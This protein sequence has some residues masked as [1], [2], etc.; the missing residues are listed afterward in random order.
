MDHLFT[1]LVAL[2]FLADLDIGF[3]YIEIQKPS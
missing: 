1:S 2:L 3:A